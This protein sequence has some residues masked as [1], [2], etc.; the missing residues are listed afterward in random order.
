MKAFF[1]GL[2]ASIVVDHAPIETEFCMSDSFFMKGVDGLYEGSIVKEFSGDE[3]IGL[4]TGKFTL[5]DHPEF[6]AAYHPDCPHCIDMAPIFKKVAK[7]VKD[8]KI[9]LEVVSVNMGK[10][11]DMAAGI[12]EYPTIRLYQQ[13]GSFKTYNGRRNFNAMTKWLQEKGFAI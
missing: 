11:D 12:D 6:V 7:A 4:L 8:K 13:D 9:P 3:A 5:N 1:I 2:V 10:T